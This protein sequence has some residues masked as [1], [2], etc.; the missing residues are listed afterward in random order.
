MRRSTL[1][2]LAVGFLILILAA[3][4]FADN[5]S[6]AGKWTVQADSPQGPVQL[7]LDLKAD[8]AQLSGTVTAF[9]SVIPISEVKF[10]D[11]QLTLKISVMQGEFKLSGVL[12]DGKLSGS[13]EQ[14]GGDMKGAWTADRSEAPASAAPAA[15]PTVGIDGI[16][17]SLAVTPE[18]DLSFDVE[19]KSAG[20]AVEGKITAGGASQPISKGSFADSKLSFELEYAGGMYRIDATL[21]GDKLTGKWSAVDGSMSGDWSAARSKP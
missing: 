10:E 5:G 7:L 11:P 4:L 21:A 14:I 8:G 18:G 1:F 16:W 3:A 15:K 12:K 17:N 19:L 6:V 13:W 20:A 9:E 2:A